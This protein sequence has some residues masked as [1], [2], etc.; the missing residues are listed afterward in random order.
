MARTTEQMQAAAA[1]AREVRFTKA[2]EKATNDPVKLRH[3][4]RIF[5]AALARGLV[6]R[7]G[8]VLE[9]SR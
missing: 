5:R 3:A 2:A 7:D 4:A 1:H 8:N 9:G 6:D